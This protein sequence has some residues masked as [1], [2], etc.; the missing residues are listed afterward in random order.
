MVYSIPVRGDVNI[1][2][3]TVDKGRKFKF[4]TNWDCC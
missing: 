3:G 2:K 4:T 1:P